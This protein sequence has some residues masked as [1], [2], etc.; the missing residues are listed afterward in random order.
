MNK[1]HHFVE[2]CK[3][4]QTESREDIQ[5]FFEGV[6]FF[7]YDDEL[8]LQAFLFFNIDNYFPDCGELLL[9]ESSPNGENT[10]QGKCDFVYLTQSNRIAIVETKFIDT[11]TTGSTERTRRTAHRKKV[12]QQV[13]VLQQKFSDRWSIPTTLIDCCVFTTEDLTHRGEATLIEAKHIP[14]KGL[15]KWQEEIKRKL[16]ANFNI[17]PRIMFQEST[18]DSGL[19]K[20]YKN[21]TKYYG[22]DVCSYSE[23]CNASKM[24]YFDLSDSD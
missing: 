15:K 20:V 7:P 18:D 2:F 10:D 8:L 6:I 19:D 11:E 14:I 23:I 24:C 4:V 22:C 3:K 17:S 5:R 1:L 13:S 12:F 21:W 16:Q 9:F